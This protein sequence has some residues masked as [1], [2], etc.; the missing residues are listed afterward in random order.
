MINYLKN[1]KLINR[2]VFFLAFFEIFFIIKILQNWGLVMVSI[3]RIVQIICFQGDVFDFLNQAKT[4]INAKG[5]AAFK[6]SF[7]PVTVVA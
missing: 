2:L 5:L 6:N 3:E 7:A 1:E 4:K